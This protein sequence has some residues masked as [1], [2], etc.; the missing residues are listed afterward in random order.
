[1][2]LPLRWFWDPWTFT[3]APKPWHSRAPGAVLGFAWLLFWLAYL[4]AVVI[5]AHGFWPWAWAWELWRE[6]AVWSWPLLV[7]YAIYGELSWILPQ[8][9]VTGLLQHAARAGHW[10]GWP[11]YGEFRLGPFH[12]YFGWEPM[13]ASKPNRFDLSA[14]W[15]THHLIREESSS[16]LT[17]LVDVLFSTKFWLGAAFGAFVLV[18]AWYWAWN[19]WVERW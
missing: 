3:A 13:G 18:P 1:M 10:I 6:P 11:P 8:P 14:R 15:L 4:P 2:N 12:A 16:M 19:R 7:A 17:L 5:H 9:A